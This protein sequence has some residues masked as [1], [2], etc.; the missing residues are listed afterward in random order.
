MSTDQ[1]YNSLGQIL[2]QGGE[3][4]LGLAIQHGWTD[5]QINQ[6]FARRFEPMQ[7]SDRQRLTD[8]AR[9]AVANVG[10]IEDIGDDSAIP[11]SSIPIN[12]ELFGEEYSGKR[13][14]FVT[15]VWNPITG[16]WIQIRLDFPG[17]PS[18]QDIANAAADELRNRSRRSPGRGNIKGVEE[19]EDLQV[20]I[21]LQERR[22]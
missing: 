21:V 17:I 9:A 19:E 22:F 14:L 6:L 8:I 15:E 11:I 5:T 4:A 12:P 2:A 20:R 16:K 13:S 3:I 1:P 10:Q 18:P 7:P